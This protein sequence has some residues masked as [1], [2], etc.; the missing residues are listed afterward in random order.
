ME[1]FRF[2]GGT[3]SLSLPY[4]V[5]T[6]SS[7]KPTSYRGSAL[8]Y[9]HR[10]KRREG[11]NLTTQLHPVPRF[12]LH[13][14]SINSIIKK[15]GNFDLLYGFLHQSFIKVILIR[16][17]FPNTWNWDHFRGIHHF[18]TYF[19]FLFYVLISLTSNLH[20]QTI[21]LAAL[22]STAV[23]STW[24]SRYCVVGRATGYELGEKGVGVRV[25]VGARIFTSSCIFQTGSG[26][27]VPEA[28]CRE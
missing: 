21:R 4:S 8:G 28:L 3:K 13:M 2:L 6:G 1:W 11:V 16:G 19:D 5:Q 26:D 23:L 7:F 9:F 18:R 14:S 20:C 27:Q 25:P 22:N 15:S 17:V 12:T 10:L 24:K